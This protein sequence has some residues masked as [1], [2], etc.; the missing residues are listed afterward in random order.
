MTPAEGW[1]TDSS[2]PV[3]VRYIFLGRGERTVNVAVLGSLGEDLPKG[4]VFGGI[5]FDLFISLA[6]DSCG[7]RTDGGST[8]SPRGKGSRMKTV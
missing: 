3:D 2:L 1:Q 4:F 5:P 6:R 8:K 7:Y